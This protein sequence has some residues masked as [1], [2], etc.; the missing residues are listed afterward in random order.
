[1]TAWKKLLSDCEF[2]YQDL[3]G[4]NTANGE[5]CLNKTLQWDM[6]YI[7]NGKYEGAY[8][9]LQI[10]NGCDIRGG[11]S[12]PHIFKFDED[13]FWCDLNDLSA[14]CPN[15]GKKEDVVA[16]VQKDLEGNDTKDP[17]LDLEHVDCYSD[18][19]GNYWYANCGDDIDGG[20]EFK[21]DEEGEHHLVC[22]K[23]GAE[24]EF[25]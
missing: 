17:A 24:I 4:Y 10:H 8:I 6:F 23:C 20:A 7:D 5:A 18:N 15:H 25:W 22:K 13:D 2:D 14:R 1:M 16:G 12:T 3:K 9:I 11:Y 19:T 21:T